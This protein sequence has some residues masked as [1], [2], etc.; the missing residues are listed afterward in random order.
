[1]ASHVNGCIGVKCAFPER[2]VICGCGD[3]GYLMA[4]FELLT[5][6]QYGIPVIWIIFNNGEFNVIKKFLLNLYGEHAYMEFGNPDYLL[7][8]QACK[9]VGYRAETLEQAEQ[10]LLEALKLNKPVLIDV[11]V[12]GNVYPPFAMGKV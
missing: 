8:A 1:M 6:V 9:A 12:E 5:A 11:Q 2:T 4:G 10:A 7:Y 3:G